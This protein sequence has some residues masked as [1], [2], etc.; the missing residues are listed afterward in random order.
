MTKNNE[1][2]GPGENGRPE[3][4]APKIWKSV[5]KI[6]K[7][8][9][10]PLEFEKW[11]ADLNFIAEVDGAIL[12]AARDEIQAQR[13]NQ[14]YIRVI[15]N[16]WKG[17]DPRG[18]RVK[19]ESRT[20]ISPD[21]IELAPKSAREKLSAAAP[22]HNVERAPARMQAGNGSEMTLD[23]L[24]IG[25]ANRHAANLVRRIAAGELPDA[26]CVTFFGL[27][28][29]GKS[30]HLKALAQALADA[31]RADEVI[32]ITANEFLSCF[33]SG[34]MV[35]DGKALAALKAR[36]A[37]AKFVLLDDLHVICGKTGTEVL[38][39]EIL[40][41]VTTPDIL[42]QRGYVFVAAD[43]APADIPG[44][45]PRIRSDLLGGVLVEL[46]MPDDAMMEQILARR[47]A[48]F[49]ERSPEF[50]LT[51][52]MMERIV[53]A[54]EEG[55]R[56]LSGILLSIYSDTVC[57]ERRVTPEIVENAIQR[58][59][60]RPVEPRVEEIKRAISEVSGVSRAVME[61]ASRQKAHCLARHLA[62]YMACRLTE[63]SL[64]QIA[65]ALGGMHHTSVMHGRD[66][67][68]ALLASTNPADTAKRTEARMLLDRATARLRQIVAGRPRVT[69]L[70]S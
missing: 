61:G 22:A 8:S 4:T 21:L 47:V 32:Y 52:E 68:T 44:L 37:G 5:R 31:G 51:P 62:M 7:S 35:G 28:G 2:G 42:G 57:N 15:N 1:H 27:Q 25:D 18:R 64:P 33:V 41:S 45:S 23:T 9:R 70:A 13:V 58:H 43:A 39:F 36:V 40:R 48:T 20:Q 53:F 65:Q 66:R 30:H 38:F 60:G 34:A 63:K 19:V 50:D 10:N 17:C 59:V 49:R 46:A 26:G 56:V 54:A 24:V 69:R 3:V 29:V 14:D 11:I 12:I 16:V 67:L 6:L 55:P